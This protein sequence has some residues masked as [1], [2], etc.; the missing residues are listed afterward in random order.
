MPDYE[1]IQISTGAAAY[2]VPDGPPEVPAFAG[3]AAVV[4]AEQENYR[5][6]VKDYE[7]Y[8]ELRTYIKFLILQAVPK[9]YTSTLADSQ[10]GYA[11]VSPLEIM[12]H[13]LTRY[14]DIKEKDLAE[15]STIIYILWDPDKPIETVFETGIFCRE[16]AEEG[17]DPISDATYTRILV[18][19]FDESGVLEKA[20]EDWEKKPKDDK[21][22]EEA[23]LHFTEANEYRHNKLS[24]TTKAVLAANSK[25]K[26]KEEPSNHQG[27]PP[28]FFADITALVAN[29]VAAQAGP[30]KPKKDKIPDRK[31]VV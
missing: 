23:I 9:I 15:N 28:S 25:T 7:T 13:L 30:T 31:S 11:N 22:L 3:T 16:F 2:E 26:T 12:T 29:I 6:A 21:D 18:S 27:I 10:L 19:I 17:D 20:V 4:A 8:Q 1:Y 24:K 5:Q 14:G